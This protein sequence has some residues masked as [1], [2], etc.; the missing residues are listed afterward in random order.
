M[1][2]SVIPFTQERATK[3]IKLTSL[4][5]GST[6]KHET[7]YL[8]KPWIDASVNIFPL[9]FFAE[10]NYWVWL[11]DYVISSIEMIA[12]VTYCS[13]NLIIWYK[14]FFNYTAIKDK[15][16]F[17]KANLSLFKYFWFY[18]LWSQVAQL[19]CQWLWNPLGASVTFA[20]LIPV[21]Y[22]P[23]VRDYEVEFQ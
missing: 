5:A 11:H 13:R 20:E 2:T 9:M 23:M 6:A 1:P 17:S 10:S 18:L 4:Q 15:Q 3:C 16:N 22:C 21:T 12:W 7:S 19:K 14:C 8:N